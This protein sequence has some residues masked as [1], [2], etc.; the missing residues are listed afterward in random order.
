MFN[1][2][3]TSYVSTES[4]EYARLIVYFSDYNSTKC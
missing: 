2:L 1:I 3:Q 4:K